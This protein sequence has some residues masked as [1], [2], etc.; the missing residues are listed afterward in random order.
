[1]VR[2]CNNF[3][4]IITTNRNVDKK[5]TLTAPSLL[6]NLLTMMA[7]I[8]KG[9]KKMWKNICVKYKNKGLTP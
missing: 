5:C 3:L 8:K 4:T 2:N 1:M 7:K 9:V 6:V